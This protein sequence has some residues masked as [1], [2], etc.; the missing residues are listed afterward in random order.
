[1]ARGVRID[2]LAM[3]ERRYKH[4]G[5]GYEDQW[6]AVEQLREGAGAL[7]ERLGG[8]AIVVDE[9]EEPASLQALKLRAPRVGVP[10]ALAEITA[11]DDHARASHALGKSYVDVVRGF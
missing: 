2:S 6:P 8:I 1:M 3:S 5:W 7:A 11:D 9:I 10:R 4:W